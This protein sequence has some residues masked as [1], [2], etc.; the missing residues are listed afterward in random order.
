MPAAVDWNQLI[1]SLLGL[2]L[3]GLGTW[4]QDSVNSLT[5]GFWAANSN[6]LTHTDM[7]MTWDLGPIAT[8]V[9][10]ALGASRAILIFA[11]VLLGIRG[12]ISGIVPQQP[13]L[14]AEF[15]GGILGAVILT[16]AFPSLI[17]LVMNLANMASDTIAS[18]T[19]L[20]GYFRGDD[21]IA[22][23]LIKA[24]LL[25]LV[26]LFGIRLLIKS[27]WRIGFLA[28]MLPV[29]AAAMPLYAI[30]QT[31]WLAGWWARVW[32]GMLMAQIPST[33]ALIIGLQIFRHGGGLGAF[34]YTIAFLQLAHDL[35]DLIP[36]G[37]ARGQG[38]PVGTAVSA[39]AAFA[40][41]LA[42]AGVGMT[43]KVGTWS[44]WQAQGGAST[45]GAGNGAATALS[46]AA[47]AGLMA[48]SLARY[49]Y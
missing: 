29:G 35:Y 4:L 1:P 46:G 39:A 38:S 9:D 47:H 12:T 44:P 41:G 45:A 14:L 5:D 13:H 30:P 23:P 8:Q 17:A 48:P 20:T 33:L 16:A 3:K 27:I 25:V 28:V 40:G 36:F 19:D 49:G 43:S 2:F 42:G 31:R 11:L 21:T 26:L 7:G 10:S 15:V 22:D 32:G 6:V 34:V 18:G 37:M 24:V